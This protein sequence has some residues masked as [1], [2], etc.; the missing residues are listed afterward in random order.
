MSSTVTSVPRES[1][2]Y[3]RYRS[4]SL[5]AVVSLLMGIISLPAL[6][7]PGL[8]VVPLVGLFFGWRAL[9]Q[10]RRAPDEWSGRGIA[11]SGLIIC[12]LVARGRLRLWR[13]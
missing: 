3:T 2:D 5:W 1:D 7:L 11:M 4:L 13:P 6:I 10:V 12:L 9:R 8:L